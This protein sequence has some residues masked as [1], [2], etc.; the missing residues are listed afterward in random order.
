LLGIR[1]LW[2]DVL[3]IIQDDH[4][5]WLDLAAKMGAIYQ[6]PLLKV[7]VHPAKDSSEG[8]LRGRT[9]PSVLEITAKSPKAAFWLDI[10]TL[11]EEVVLD[12]I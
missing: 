10:P 9:I 3:C 2:I 8:F 6:R 4:R 1:F 7:A 5:D 12:S 11:S